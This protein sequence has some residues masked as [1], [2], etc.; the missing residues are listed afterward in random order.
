MGLDMYL[1]K[2]TYVKNWEHTAKEQRHSFSVKIGGKVR[3]DIKPER[4]SYITEEVAYWRKFNALHGW[5]VEQCGGGVDECQDI[6]VEEEKMKE[7]L[8]VLKKV[9]ELI[10]KSNPVVKVEKD[11]NGKD[12]EYK[13]FDCEDE[14]RE[15]FSPTQGFFFG[16]DNIDEYYKQE[17]ENTIEVIENL[18]KE[19]EDTD[20]VKGLYSGDF[21]YRASW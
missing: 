12:Y 6:Y 7:L 15:L 3:K 5:F 1:Y 10:N 14:V 11:W 16:S 18:L 2:K 20:A 8:D 21:Y 4:I 13:T 9:S 17:V 19:C